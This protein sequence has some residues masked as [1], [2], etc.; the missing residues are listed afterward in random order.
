MVARRMRKILTEMHIRLINVGSG[1]GVMGILADGVT[2]GDEEV[3]GIV[4]IFF[5]QLEINPHDQIELIV[6]DNMHNRKQCADIT[7]DG[8][9]NL[10][11]EF[12][13]STKF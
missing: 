5:D 3:I 11:R 1:V 13:H 6:I 4:P 2:N 8:I 12:G 9:M 7:A 10:P